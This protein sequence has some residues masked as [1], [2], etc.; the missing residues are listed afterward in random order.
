[1]KPL[2]IL[3]SFTLWEAKCIKQNLHDFKHDGKF[4]AR[5]LGAEENF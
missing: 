2:L 1:M 3:I 4:K 5:P